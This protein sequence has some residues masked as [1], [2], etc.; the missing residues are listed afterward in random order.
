MRGEDIKQGQQSSASEPGSA[1]SARAKLPLSG[2]C[3]APKQL[4]RRDGG[5]EGHLGSSLQQKGSPLLLDQ[6]HQSTLCPCHGLMCFPA[7][8]AQVTE[9]SK[10]CLQRREGGREGFPLG[11]EADLITHHTVGVARAA[12]PSP[13]LPSAAQAESSSPQSSCT[14]ACSP[15]STI[16]AEKIQHPERRRGKSFTQFNRLSD[17]VS[18]TVLGGMCYIPRGLLSV[19]PMLNYGE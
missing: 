3:M 7:W 12:T 15:P 17:Y 11:K 14:A 19:I 16:S 4:Q 8:R 6:Q 2:T 5:G 13:P 1:A 9:E 18:K 10:L